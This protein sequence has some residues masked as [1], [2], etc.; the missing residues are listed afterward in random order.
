MDRPRRTVGAWR[1]SWT[2]TPEPFAEF[3]LGLGMFGLLVSAALFGDAVVRDV[4]TGMDPLLFASSLRKVEYLGGRFLA[5]L[6]INA[7]VLVAVPLG[8]AAATLMPFFDPAVFV[9]FRAAAYVQPYLL[10]LLP[11]LV[12]AGAI[13]FTTGV[14]SRQVIP[15][16][17]GAI[18]II[19]GYL[20]ASASLGHIDNPMLTVLADPLGIRA[21]SEVTAYCPAPH[22]HN[23][24][25]GRADGVPSSWMTS[26]QRLIDELQAVVCINS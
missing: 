19:I 20:I 21:T 24:F 15:V 5:A 7:V 9:P 17:L 25:G 3:T 8:L 16:Y 18:G 12:L 4:Q 14:L 6:A 10:A 26:Q 22:D 2:Y 11:N 1:R 23:T 13:L